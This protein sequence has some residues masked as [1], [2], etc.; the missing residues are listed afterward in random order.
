MRLGGLIATRRVWSQ[1]STKGMRP[2]RRM[3]NGRTYSLGAGYVGLFLEISHKRISASP[4]VLQFVRWSRDAEGCQGPVS[5]PN[6]VLAPFRMC[7]SHS[8]IF[9]LNRNDIPIAL[10]VHHEMQEGSVLRRQATLL[11]QQGLLVLFHERE[12]EVLQGADILFNTRAQ[13][14]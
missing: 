6:G 9:E 13:A 14:R 11:W 10:T 3:V 2:D 5:L 12:M 1:T 8:R 7:T 4:A